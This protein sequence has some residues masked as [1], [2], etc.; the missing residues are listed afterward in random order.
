MKRLAE[1]KQGLR[2]GIYHPYDCVMT[3]KQWL[4]YEGGTKALKIDLYSSIGT[5]YDSLYILK[6]LYL[7][8]AILVGLVKESIN[9]KFGYSY[10]L[11]NIVRGKTKK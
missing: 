4:E 11:H 1:L 3:K 5:L 8:Q 10:R 9:R 6:G 2:S 7:N